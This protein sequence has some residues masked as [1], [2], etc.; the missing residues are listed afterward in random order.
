MKDIHNGG[1]K[2]VCIPC[3]IERKQPCVFYTKAGKLTRY[4]FSCGY[5]EKKGELT[6]EMENGTY[7]VKGWINDKH[8]W[9]SFDKITPARKF[10]KCLFIVGVAITSR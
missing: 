10:L 4:A 6:L 3:S 2:N 1:R 8:V 9:V 7:H 5:V